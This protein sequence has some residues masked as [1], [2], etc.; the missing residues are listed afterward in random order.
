MVPYITICYPWSSWLLL[1]N[2]SLP[3]NSYMSAPDH[4]LRCSTTIKDSTV[5]FK[6]EEMLPVGE[7]ATEGASNGVIAVALGKPLI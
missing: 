2:I 5:T 1:P 4:E 6:F 3:L 7:V